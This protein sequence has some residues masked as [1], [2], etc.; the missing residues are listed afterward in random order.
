MRQWQSHKGRVTKFMI[1]TWVI[2]ISITIIVSTLDEVFRKKSGPQS[3]FGSKIVTYIMSGYVLV[4]TTAIIFVY[5]WISYLVLVRHKKFDKS[6]NSGERVSKVKLFKMAI[7]RERATLTICLLVQLSFVS[8]NLPIAIRF[9]LGAKEGN[10]EVFL[11]M[12]NSSLNPLIYFFKGYL[13]KEYASRKAAIN[14]NSGQGVELKKLESNLLRK[15]ATE[16]LDAN[17][18]EGDGKVEDGDYRKRSRNSGGPRTGEYNETE[19]K[20]FA[21]QDR[22]IVTQHKRTDSNSRK[23]TELETK[24]IG[25]RGEDSPQS[26]SSLLEKS[27]QFPNKWLLENRNSESAL[28]SFMMDREENVV[29][30]CSGQSQKQREARSSNYEDAEEGSMEDNIAEN[31]HKESL[32]QEIV[33]QEIGIENEAVEIDEPESIDTD[34][35]EFIRAM[36]VAYL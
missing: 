36:V 4:S 11:V 17:E 28:S 12:A 32:I 19:L 14:S 7:R 6:A 34:E 35:P 30:E 33:V 23:E 15:Q 8:C 2:N 21:G 31:V 5:T 20:D 9:L 1:L 27:F 13:E 26:E 18:R 22:E 25:A 24:K 3:L 16:K 29:P 10:P